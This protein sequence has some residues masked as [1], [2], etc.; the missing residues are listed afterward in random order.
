MAKWTIDPAHSEIGFKV[1]HLMISTVSGKFTRF[2]AEAE[3]NSEDDFLGA[4][5][6][7]SAEVDSIQTGMEARD[8]HLKSEEFFHASAFPQIQFQSTGF[9]K[10]GDDSYDLTGNLTIRDVSKPIALRVVFQGLMQDFS[11]NTK[12]GFEVTGI[13]NRH[14]FG[15]KWN[16]I[17]EAGGIVVSDHVKLHMDIQMQRSSE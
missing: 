7:F 4:L 6:H 16:A 9:E 2:H 8:S 14:D 5:I 12:A 11:G 13:I 15:L 17:T 10:S 3:T 1:K